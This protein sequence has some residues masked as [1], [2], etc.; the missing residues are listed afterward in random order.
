MRKTLA[1][2]KNKVSLLSIALMFQFRNFLRNF[3]KKTSLGDFYD[4]KL[5]FGQF[6]IVHDKTL[7]AKD[8][9]SEIDLAFLV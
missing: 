9:T 4:P 2:N 1:L 7:W 5:R 3:Q 6:R 8:G